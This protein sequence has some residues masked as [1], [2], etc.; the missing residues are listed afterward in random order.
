M[1]PIFPREVV[2]WGEQSVSALRKATL[3]IVEI[4]AL[5]GIAVRLLRAAV[6]G[7]STGGNWI[8]FVGGVTAG[9]LLLCGALTAHLM[10][11]PMRRWLVRV[12]LFAVIEVAAEAGMSSI[13]IALGREPLGAA[14][15]RW[16]DWWTLA[17]QTLVERGVALVLFAL[18][19]A[20]CVQLAR[21]IIDGRAAQA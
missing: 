20:G 10:N 11:Y 2:H 9:L 15:A 1:P 7:P 14:R 6:L 4:A 8:V 3:S 16:G 12:P 17:G 13:L 19:L 21:R 18:V 5:T